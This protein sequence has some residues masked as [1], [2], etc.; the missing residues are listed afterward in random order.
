MKNFVLVSKDAM[1]TDYLPTYGNTRWK[2]PNI[3]AIAAQGTVFRNHYTAAPST[4]MTFH[5]MCMGI[6]PHETKYE[7]YEKIHER[8]E[9]PTAFTRLREKGFECHIV[10][11]EMW[12][13]IFNYYDYFRD[14]VAIH[15]LQGLRQG[16]GAHYVHKGFLVPDPAKTEMA[17]NLVKREL[18]GIFSR[19]GPIFLWIHFPH[20]ING[21]VSYGS[22]I[23]VF[24]R[25]VGMVRE[26]ADDDRIAITA[27]HGNQNGHRGKIG[28]AFDVYQESARIPLITPRIG[29]NAEWLKPTSNIDI[30]D[31][32]FGHVPER[33]F[34][35][36][37]TAYRAQRHRKLAIVRDR[38]KYIYN[39]DSGRE[40]LYDLEFD[41]NEQFS[42]MED[43]V[44][45]PD[46]KIR[47]PSRE[48]YYY[49]SWDELP[50]IR[51]LLR[52][53]KDR[54]WKNGSWPVV[55]KSAA[56]DWVRPLYARLSKKKIANQP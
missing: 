44:Y 24:D 40:E 28:Y 45:D 34:I 50:E 43:Y 9:G 32:V 25:F 3:D 26:Y 56:K 31:I 41:P 20:V 21:S 14:D 13:N 17:W 37:D 48:L 22:D 52:A 27:D 11:D 29:T 39:K 35:Y 42:V 12:M 4:I 53:E 30:F 8:V 36:V 33:E 19:K 55:L 15:S 23:E 46:R 10:W 54:I 2:T 1:C 7:M 38:F 16:V 18:D 47:A 49:P 5:A 51:R 6:C